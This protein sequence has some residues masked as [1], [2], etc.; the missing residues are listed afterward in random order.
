MTSVLDGGYGWGLVVSATPR[1]RFIPG[2]RTAGIHW[3]TLYWLSYPGSLA[4]VK[5]SKSYRTRTMAPDSR[6]ERLESCWSG[7]VVRT[8]DVKPS[9]SIV[10]CVTDAD[11]MPTLETCQNNLWRPLLH[12]H[13]KQRWKMCAVL[14]FTCRFCSY[15]S[16]NCGHYEPFNKIERTFTLRGLN[17]PADRLT[18]Y[19]TNKC[20]HAQFN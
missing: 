3:Q 19:G 13:I 8:R 2:E 1:P 18:I 20:V 11:V 6:N 14:I 4:L 7:V 12:C 5:R 17:K 10:S 16:F 9:D 15:F